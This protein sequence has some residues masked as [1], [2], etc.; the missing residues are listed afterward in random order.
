MLNQIVIG[1]VI[2]ILTIIVQVI[3]LGILSSRFDQIRKM[4]SKDYRHI[5]SPIIIILSVLWIVL[6]LT[7][8]MW[9]WAFAFL[10]VGEFSELEE[11]LYF[12]I[13]SFTTLGFGDVILSQQWRIM[14]ALSAVNGLLVFGLNAAFLVEL[15]GI[16]W[17]K[18]RR[19]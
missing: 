11:S 7:I 6:G 5:K 17:G 18:S 2:I 15:M 19:K 10:L 13:A 9:I 4:D 12:A 1:S 14:G 8:D 3:F 16:T